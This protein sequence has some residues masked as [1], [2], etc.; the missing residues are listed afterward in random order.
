MIKM[1][2]EIINKLDYVSSKMIYVEPTPNEEYTIDRAIVC[3]T[4]YIVL[5][6]FFCWWLFFLIPVYKYMNTK[7]DRLSKITFCC[8]K[9]D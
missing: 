9:G 7:L 8:K 3:L 5:I 1:I 2:C 6:L 4:I